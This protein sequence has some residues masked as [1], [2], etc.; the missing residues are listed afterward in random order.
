MPSSVLPDSVDGQA[1]ANYAKLSDEQK[2]VVLLSDD[3]EGEARAELALPVVNC[4]PRVAW[5][6]FSRLSQSLF[7]SVNIPTLC[8]LCDRIVKCASKDALFNAVAR[9][10]VVTLP[11]SN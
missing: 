8:R 11:F 2:R 5:A 6:I 4:A 9:K 7:T 1:K 10:A 3:F